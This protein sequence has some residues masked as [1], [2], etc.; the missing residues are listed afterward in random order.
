MSHRFR[1]CNSSSTSSTPLSWRRD[2]SQSQRVQ[3]EIET[4]QGSVP[5]KMVDVTVVPVHRCTSWKGRPRSHSCSLYSKT[6]RSLSP[7]A[8]SRETGEHTCPPGLKHLV[9]KVETNT[10]MASRRCCSIVHG[11]R[12]LRVHGREPALGVRSWHPSSRRVAAAMTNVTVSN[13]TCR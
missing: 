11:D 4:P 6:M 12:R 9:K 7:D 3:K 5:D 2:K 1:S 10:A 8:Q 13:P